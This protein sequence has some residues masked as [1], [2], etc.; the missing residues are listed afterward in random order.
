[1][2]QTRTLGEAPTAARTFA[3]HVDH[4]GHMRPLLEELVYALVRVGREQR[5]N[6]LARVHCRI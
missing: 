1:M 6:R 5:H 4:L 2:S 3:C